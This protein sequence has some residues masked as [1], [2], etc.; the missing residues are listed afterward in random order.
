MDSSL[1]D[2]ASGTSG[3]ER[4]SIYKDENDDSDFDEAT[5]NNNFNGVVREPITPVVTTGG[6]GSSATS[7]LKVNGNKL[8]VDDNFDSISEQS[9]HSE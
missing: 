4:D 6:A 3:G 7:N 8:D 2:T 9:R 1:N 5:F